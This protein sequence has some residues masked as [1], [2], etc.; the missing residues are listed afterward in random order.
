MRHHFEGGPLRQDL[1]GPVRS[2]LPEGTQAERWTR[3]PEIT[4]RY[5][6]EVVVRTRRCGSVISRPRVQIL[7]YAAGRTSQE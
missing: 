2:A 7:Q 5:V 3:Q 4:L 6:A 1:Q